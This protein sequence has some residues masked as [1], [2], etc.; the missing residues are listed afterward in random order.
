MIHNSFEHI[1]LLY[2]YISFNTQM[3]Y[4]IRDAINR[5]PKQ[6]EFDE[7]KGIFNNAVKVHGRPSIC[8]KG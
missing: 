1:S 4:D 3:I 5:L 8:T 2:H 6:R 7:I